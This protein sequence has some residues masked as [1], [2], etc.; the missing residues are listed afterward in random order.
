[1]RGAARV[2]RAVGAV[3]L[4]AA[5]GGCLW[6]NFEDIKLDPPVD[7]LDRPNWIQGAYGTVMAS[8]STQSV[9]LVGGL[10]LLSGAG[11]F[12][13]ATQPPPLLAACESAAQCRLLSTPTM[14]TDRA[15]GTGCFVYGVGPGHPDLGKDLGLLGG[16]ASG[17]LFKVPLPPSMRDRAVDALFKPS[18][19][20]SIFAGGFS[21]ASSGQALAVGSPDLGVV[22]LYPDLAMPPLLVEV[23]A[24]ADATFARSLAMSGSTVLAVGAP[25]QGKV[26]VYDVAP[27]KVSLRA[28]LRRAAPYGVVLH[29]FNS[30]QRHLLAISDAA[31]QV[32]IIDADLVTPAAGCIE[33]PSAAVVDMLRCAEEDSV[34]GCADSAF[35]YAI[36][37][38]D[39]NG[40]DLPEVIVG[41]PGLNVRDVPNAGALAIF[42]LD[43]LANQPRYLFLSSAEAE[44][45]VGSSV[46]AFQLGGRVVLASNANN[47]QKTPLFH[48]ASGAPSERCR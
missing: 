4:A 6:T 1:M 33:V 46:A 30:K 47:K 5:L 22:A 38:A 7:Y 43:P 27:G 20:Q 12:S 2:A 48:C 13:F 24:E 26:F 21:L 9:L 14:V 29:G 36:T 28:C 41:A 23:P 11:V 37:T 31:G 44:E 3:A 42:S 40:D 17:P 45:R 35:G 10:P 8:Q 16:C 18:A 39:L 34:T 19:T 25:N 32:D 15:G